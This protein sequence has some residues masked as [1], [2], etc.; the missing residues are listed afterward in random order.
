[1]SRWI[2][3]ESLSIDSASTRPFLPRSTQDESLSLDSATVG[4]RPSAAAEAAANAIR[5][6][7]AA[8]QSAASAVITT[9]AL[10]HL[11]P[12]VSQSR[13]SAVISTPAATPV[14]DR[15]PSQ[16]AID[17]ATETTWLLAALMFGGYVG[18]HIDHLW[19]VG[20]LAGLF[21]GS[22]IWN[23]WIKPD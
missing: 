10:L 15:Q 13:A 21:S 4:G 18:D 22:H 5:R 17:Q 19:V 12:A 9:P 6:A 23:R 20:A 14:P 1:M 16:R 8:S 11:S 2:H 7:S 3:D